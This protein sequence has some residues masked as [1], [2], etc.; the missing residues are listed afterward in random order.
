MINKDFGNGQDGDEY[1]DPL[2]MACCAE[3][4]EP[5]CE[6]SASQSCHLDLIQTSCQSLPARISQKADEQALPGPKEALLNLATWIGDNQVLC[7]AAFGSSE[8]ETTAPS[9]AAGDVSSYGS[10]LAGK[11]WVIP[12]TFSGGTTV[13]SN[14]MITADQVSVTGIHTGSENCWSLGDND[15][16]PH[17]LEIFPEGP[18]IKTN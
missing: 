7:K 17:V 1:A 15:G 3:V 6:S 12:G 4:T 9:C 10:L 5:F 11:Q 8:V 14:V 16:E 2:V 13:I 18:I